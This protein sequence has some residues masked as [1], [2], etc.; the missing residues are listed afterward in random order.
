M[1]AFL[2]RL[3]ILN[4]LLLRYMYAVPADG[5]AESNFLSLED[6]GLQNFD[7]TESKEKIVCVVCRELCYPGKKLRLVR[8]DRADIPTYC[9]C[10]KSTCR[11]LVPGQGSAAGGHGI[12]DRTKVGQHGFQKKKV[13]P[14]LE[15]QPNVV[16]FSD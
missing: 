3:V 10:D 16:Y 13:G 4:V 7:A 15:A 8:D 2:A 11:C 5:A 6:D 14:A 1:N 9:Q 12:L